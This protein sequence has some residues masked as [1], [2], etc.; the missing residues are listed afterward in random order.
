[1]IRTEFAGRSSGTKR[2]AMARAE[3][4]SRFGGAH[5]P[6][7]IASSTGAVP[8]YVVT[9]IRERGEAEERDDGRLVFRLTRKVEALGQW[10]ERAMR[11]CVVWDPQESQL[12]DVV[13]DQSFEDMLWEAHRRAA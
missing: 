13:E 8:G 9:T 3:A 4:R 5:A 10:A 7:H 11:V 1:M 6:F 12:I 2:E